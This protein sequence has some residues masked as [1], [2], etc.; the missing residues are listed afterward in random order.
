MKAKFRNKNG[1]LSAYGLLC[2]YVQMRTKAGIERKM[3]MEHRHYHVMKFSESG[4]RL[5]WE[6]FCSN[7][8]T[9]ARKFYNNNKTVR[10]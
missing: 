4:E 1:E 3:Y 8:L 9:K 10:S 2:G 6:V 5:C 7:E